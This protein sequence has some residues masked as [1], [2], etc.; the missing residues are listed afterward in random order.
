MHTRKIQIIAGF[1]VI[2]TTGSIEKMKKTFKTFVKTRIFFLPNFLIK[3]GATI[4]G[5]KEAFP[6]IAVTIEN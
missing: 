4:L 3:N 6:A 5:Q 1:P 2:L